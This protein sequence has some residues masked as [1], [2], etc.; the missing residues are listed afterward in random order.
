MRSVPLI[1]S[2]FAV[3][4]VVSAATADEGLTLVRPGTPASGAPAL[5]GIDPMVLKAQVLLDR[6]GFSPGVI[7]GQMSDN[8]SRAVRAFQHKSGL[9]PH[10][11]LDETTL[12]RL[13]A[14][15]NEPVLIPYTIAARDVSGP[16]TPHIPEQLE[17]MAELDRLDYREPLELLAE[18]FHADERLLARLNP[19]KRFDQAGTVI[20][21]P[22]VRQ[23]PPAVKAATVEVR[24][25]DRSVRVLTREGDLAAIF[26]A[27]VGSDERPAPSGRRIVTRI[28]LNPPYTYD[29]AFGFPGVRATQKLRIAPGPNSPVGSVWIGLNERSYGIHGTAEPSQ[30][31]KV[32][33]HGCVRLT[34]WDAASLARMVSR[35]TTVVFME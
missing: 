29:P 6:A 28:V 23:R 33:S 11:H 12:S 31:G 4:A 2:L 19:D 16:F 18:K 17:K 35:G 34:N 25:R 15:S 26:P 9:E 1:G 5:D 27:S 21:V 22:N 20:L 24:K 3:A 13:S 30:V 14:R 10:G 7:D 32:N 8:L